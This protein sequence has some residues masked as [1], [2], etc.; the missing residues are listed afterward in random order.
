MMAQTMIERMAQTMTTTL[1]HHGV[2][3]HPEDIKG[4]AHDALV[5]MR[6]PTPTILKVMRDTVPVDGHEWDYV[7]EDAPAH[8]SSLIDA[9]QEEG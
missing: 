7:D 4:L 2:E 9:A 6:E 5:A 8:W 1:R 3:M